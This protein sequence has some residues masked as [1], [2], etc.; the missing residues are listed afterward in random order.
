MLIS[1]TEPEPLRRLGTVG[2]LPERLG[3]DFLMW[4]QVSGGWLGVQRKEMK[5]LIASIGD[6]RFAE[7]IVKLKQT[8]TPVL[9]LEGDGKWD[10]D[11]KW[12][13]G[14]GTYK[15]ATLEKLLMSVQRMGVQVARTRRMV[16]PCSTAEWLVG[17]EEWCL[18]VEHTALA[19]TRGPVAKTWGTAND[20]DYQRHLLL[21]LEGCG[22]KLA[23]DILDTI[24]MPLTWKEGALEGLLTVKGV[25]P[26]KVEKWS[27]ALS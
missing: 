26:K 25:G 4:D 8:N 1:P 3:A 9:V 12:D 18:K 6:G 16:G 7:Q 13:T 11:G 15:W 19:N 22:P 5:D 27:R 20:R 14:Y 24:G 23:D 21:G 10:R 2:D 17:M